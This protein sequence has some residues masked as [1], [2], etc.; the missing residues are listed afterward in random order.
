MWN[1]QLFIPYFDDE[2]SERMFYS[3]ARYSRWSK[4][5]IVRDG[6]DEQTQQSGT[7]YPDCTGM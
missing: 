4:L 5:T 6:D 7:C 2:S 3:C 1:S